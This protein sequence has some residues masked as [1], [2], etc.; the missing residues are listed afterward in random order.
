M[1]IKLPKSFGRRKSSGNILEDVEEPNSPS[2]R[3]F[4]RPGPNRSMTDGGMLTKRMSEGNIVP[5]MLEDDNIFIDPEQPLGKSRYDRSWSI[6]HP[7]KSRKPKLTP[8]RRSGA[9][10][11]SSTSTRLSSSSTQPSSTEV[12]PPDDR[13][14]HARVHD[15]PVPPPLSGALRAAGRT[16]SFGGRFKSNNSIP[17]APPRHA[18]PD[19]TSRQRTVSGG[20]DDTATPPKLMDSDFNLAAGGDDFGKMFDHLDKPDN[21]VLRDRSP[22]RTSQFSSSP[23]T[24]ALPDFQATRAPRPAPISTD[25]SVPVEPSPYSW[26]SRHSEEG[27]LGADGNSPID[28]PQENI[29][30]RRASPGPNHMLGATTTHRA[31]ERPR[32]QS[33]FD[34]LRRS[35]VFAGKRDSNTIDDEDAAMVRNSLLWSKG[36]SSPPQWA[37]HASPSYGTPL[38]DKGKAASSP[39]NRDPEPESLFVG[40]QSPNKN[41]QK[42]STLADARLA[43]QFAESLPKTA[44]PGN[45]V[46]TPSQFEHYRQQQELRR[47]NSNA[48]KSDEDSDNDDIEDDEDEIEKQREREQ[49]RRKQ[50]ANL[51]LYRQSM[52]K[53]TGQQAPSPLLRPVVNGASNST[54]NLH[55]SLPNAGVPS[56]V[57]KSSEDDD[58]EIPLGILAAHGFPNR[59]RPPTRLANASSNP[60][61]RASMHPFSSSSSSLV[62]GV[63]GIEQGNRNSTLPV[64]ARNLPPD[65]YFGA[66]LVNHSNRESLALGGGS[67]HGGAPPAVPGGLVGVI[68]KEEQARAMRRGSPN[69]QAMFDNPGMPASPMSASEQAQV[70]LSKQMTDMMQVQMQWMQQ[71][72]AIQGGQGAP[73]M[74]QPPMMQGPPSMHGGMPPPSTIGQAP[75]PG[76]PQGPPMMGPPSIA[77]SAGMRPVSMPGYPGNQPAR[78]QRTLSVIDP[79]IAMRRTGSPMPNL[80]GASTNFRPSTGYA[81]SIAPSERS[82]VGLA[83]RYRPVSVMQGEAGY[84]HT[85]PSN[86]SWNDENRLHPNI[87]TSQSHG[88]LGKNTTIATVTVRPV[89]RSSQVP[90]VGPRAPAGSDDDDDEAW[91]EMMKK[92][93]KKKSGWKLKKG[94]P[95][96]GDILGAVH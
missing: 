9:T 81:P 78:D 8:R 70:Q 91:A 47:S 13:S 74:M 33:D 71:M 42:D 10:Y 60:N 88:S 45:K 59:N 96:L 2:F 54:P 77:P 94:N 16:F 11:E 69:T 46:M 3:V 19:Q 18:T 65:P 35:V 76:T 22:Q 66:G 85:S 23:P 37:D 92:R 53:V 63:V 56:S 82:N 40:R 95:P 61:L 67:V 26:G 29:P 68:A 36:S 24:Q 14:P 5:S 38:L 86:K 49:Q 43:I 58:E 73:P 48:T 21:V 6:V 17:P 87:P 90:S 30:L 32:R 83:S 51:S 80:Q 50:E 25:R 89:S 20:T 64:F 34:G 15:I 57:G 12:P 75:M 4:E 39:E 62:G 1:P 93:D 41:Q 28:S 52:M 7:F 27:L 31:L 79:N 55:S 44:S 84:S 72:M